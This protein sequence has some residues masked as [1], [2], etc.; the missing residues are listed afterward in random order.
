MLVPS[1]LLL[2]SVGVAL[3]SYVLS[4]LAISDPVLLALVSACA[5]L[6]LLV[7]A[8][9]GGRAPQKAASAPLR[10]IVVDGS[11]IMH[12]KGETAQLSTLQEVVRSLID[13]GYQPGVVFDANAGYKLT[14]RYMDDGPLAYA[15]GLPADRVLVVPK[16]EPADPV[17]LKV[18]RDLGALVLSND[19]FRDWAAEF[20]EVAQQG[21]L[22]RGGYRDGVLWMEISS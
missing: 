10:S 12:W 4:G 9:L 18:A 11:N 19:R 6:F 16:G 20:P 3:V 2:I 22:R 17:I 5:A 15:L 8:G 14:G 21:H 7:R 13:H 1:I